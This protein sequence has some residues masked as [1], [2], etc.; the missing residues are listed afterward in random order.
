LSLA[1]AYFT[2]LPPQRS[3]IADYSA[4]LL[5][6]LAEK[7]AIELYVDDPAQIEPQW[8]RRFPMR[9]IA[10]FLAHPALR[11]RYDLCLYH[12]GNQPLYHEQIYQALMRSP[13]IVV[14]HEIHLLGFYLHRPIE[15]AG[16]AAFMREMGYAY[17]LPGIQAARAL[18]SDGS[19]S[20]QQ[21]YPLFN[22]IAKVSQGII[23]HTR[24][25]S[26]QVLQEVPQARVIDI[27]LAAHTSASAP[28][29]EKPDWLAHLPADAVV[30][31]SLGYIAPSKRIDRVLQA[32][33]RLRDASPNLYY[34]LVGEPADHYDLASVIHQ[35]RLQDRVHI[36]GFVDSATFEAYVQMI[37]IGI[38]LRTGPTGGEMSAGVTRLLAAGR[39]TIVSNVGG[40]A[41]LPDECA[42]KIE[43]DES[44]LEQLTAVLQQLILKPDMRATYRANAA[45]YAQ[46]KLSFKQVAE[47][48]ADFIRASL[49]AR[50]ASDLKR[51]S[52]S[53]NVAEDRQSI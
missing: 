21:A 17:G 52:R 11:W 8:T 38:C 44:E 7:F 35:L 27:P 51:L 22:R 13:G 48:Y 25:A 2:P 30:L 40:F 31:A 36:T 15:E 47:S 42:I 24:A 1:I 50:K 9:S 6:Y 29:L 26:A 46:T 5:P 10:D 53:I 43:Q 19:A 32:V 20:E 4:T 14:L 12:M 49:P 28:V 41:E 16:P 45:R 39:P 33:A 34:V 37:D 3:G 23:V 18:L